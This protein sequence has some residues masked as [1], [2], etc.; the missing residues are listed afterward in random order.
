MDKILFKIAFVAILVFSV[1]SLYQRTIKV[2]TEDKST[3]K[4]LKDEVKYKEISSLP[5]DEL[6]DQLIRMFP[7]LVQPE[8]DRSG[9]LPKAT[10]GQNDT[11]FESPNEGMANGGL[12]SEE[13]M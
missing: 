4:V 2:E 6:N 5:D 1:W 7:E 9:Q 10:S 3:I 11:W 12:E 8:D 13:R